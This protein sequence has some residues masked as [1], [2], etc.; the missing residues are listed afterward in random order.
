MLAT[1]SFSP[2]SRQRC[3]RLLAG[4]ALLL[5]AAM[6]ACAPRPVVGSAP[7]PPIPAGEG[8]IWVYRDFIPSESLNM[9]EVTFNGVYA[10]YSQL[11]GAFYR[12][13]PPGVYHVAV[14]SY[15]VDFNQSTNIGLVPGQQAYIKIELLRDWATGYGFGF[16]AG[17]DTFYARQMPIRLARA[18]IAQSFYDGGS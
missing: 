11:G 15:G 4:A 18:Q 1:P 17:R 8:R 12:D 10:G 13:V 7:I 3:R 6:G 14:N 2:I 16:T 9:T 5:P